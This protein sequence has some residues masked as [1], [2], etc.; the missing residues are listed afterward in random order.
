LST[1]LKVIETIPALARRSFGTG[2]PTVTITRTTTVTFE[3]DPT[4]SAKHIPDPGNCVY[5]F[6]SA[7]IPDPALSDSNDEDQTLHPHNL[8]DDVEDDYVSESQSD[9]A[10]VQDADQ[11]PSSGD[12]DDSDDD[13]HDQQDCDGLNSD[14]QNQTTDPHPTCHS[15]DDDSVIDDDHDKGRPACSV[16][17]DKADLDAC[18]VAQHDE[19]EEGEHLPGSNHFN[20]FA[21]TSDPTLLSDKVTDPASNHDS[22]FDAWIDA[23][24]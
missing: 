8:I 9:T 12:L 18:H 3:T 5:D 11:E 10:S 20:A 22:L 15:Y 1:P 7:A 4:Q 23:Y 17:S 6:D 19:D 16:H 13:D 2:S 21:V 24:N 14:D